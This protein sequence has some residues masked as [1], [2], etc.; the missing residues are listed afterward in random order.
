[1]EGEC[2]RRASL[3]AALRQGQA[4]SLWGWSL[5]QGRC[6]RHRLRRADSLAATLN[7]TEE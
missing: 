1:M 2:L 5:R 3:A 4:D 6:Q 7:R